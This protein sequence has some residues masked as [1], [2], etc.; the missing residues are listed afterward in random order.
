M[1]DYFNRIKSIRKKLLIQFGLLITFS[2]LLMVIMLFTIEK[3][4]QFTTLRRNSLQLYNIV[5][6]MRTAEKD[7]II[8]DLTDE[9]FYKNGSSTN[10]SKFKE[11]H[12]EA[13]KRILA[14]QEFP[15]ASDHINLDSLKSASA[16]LDKYASRFHDLSELYKQR[17]FKD[18]GL[19]GTLRQAIHDIEKGSENFDK[20]LMLTLRRNEKDFL[21]RLDHQYVVKFDTTLAKFLTSARENGNTDAFIEKV[22][23]YNSAF[24]LMVDL[25]KDLGTS[26]DKGI[27]GD[28]KT[29]VEK[30][31]PVLEGLVRSIS[32]NVDSTTNKAYLFLSWE[33]LFILQ[34][35]F[36]SR[37]QMG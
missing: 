32:S 11:L 36:Q 4:T 5:Y 24:H 13:H 7:F 23:T 30:M 21:L 1:F 25:Y 3:I 19:E 34:S 10:I 6:K 27:K 33:L 8:Q 15:S 29:S 9:N 17:G 22:N 26:T 28:L 12:Q 37:Q 35:L 16:F 2:M 14:I 31:D 20:V 18:F